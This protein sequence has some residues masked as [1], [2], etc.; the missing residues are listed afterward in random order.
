M[1]YQFYFYRWT[2]HINLPPPA[3]RQKYIRNEIY[4]F[5]VLEVLIC[6]R[7]LLASD[8]ILIPPVLCFMWDKLRHSAKQHTIIA[9]LAAEKA[10]RIGV[11]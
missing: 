7:T 5:L 11:Q 9:L 3:E 2:V 1:L 8:I 10:R 6:M 4:N